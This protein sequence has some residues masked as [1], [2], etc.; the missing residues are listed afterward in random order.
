MFDIV[1]KN[2]K[3]AF[4]VSFITNKTS[5]NYNSISHFLDIQ[6]QSNFIQ[7]NIHRP[8]K[9]RRV[10]FLSSTHHT[11]TNNTSTSN[12]GT[13][14]TTVKNTINQHNCIKHPLLNKPIAQYPP[15]TETTHNQLSS[16]T[17]SSSVYT[18]QDTTITLHENKSADFLIVGFLLCIDSNFIQTSPALQLEYIK[19]LKYKLALELDTHNLYKEYVYNKIRSLQKTVLQDS[20]F[21]NKNIQYRNLYRY[22]GDYFNVNFISIIDNIFIEYYNNFKDKRI[23]I[24]IYN[25]NGR[26]TIDTTTNRDEYICDTA[27]DV[28]LFIKYPG[29]TFKDYNKLKLKDIQMIATKKNIPIKVCTKNKTKKILIEEILEKMMNNM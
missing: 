13:S 14:N 4:L 26:H 23:N 18:V 15:S 27:L 12:T 25:N 29:Q 21:N 17:Q 11:V 5:S 9:K 6:K 28:S 8:S 7:T 24:I 1:S 3:L 2:K 22:I 16:H 20:L 19:T 10:T